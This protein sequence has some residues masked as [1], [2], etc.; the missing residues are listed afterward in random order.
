[1]KADEKERLMPSLQEA[2]WLHVL[3]YGER[4]TLEELERRVAKAKEAESNGEEE[5]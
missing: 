4:V 5:L 3:E 2:T 1:M